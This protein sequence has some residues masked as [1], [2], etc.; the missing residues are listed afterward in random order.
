MPQE[1]QLFIRALPTNLS[2]EKMA[3][4]NEKLRF[5]SWKN[6]EV[7]TEW[8]VLSIKTGYLEPRPDMEEFLLLV[9]LSLFSLHCILKVE[10]RIF[11]YEK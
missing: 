6:A 11:K 10:E 2:V 1:W 3:L 5:N 7:A 9:N 4:L 8:F